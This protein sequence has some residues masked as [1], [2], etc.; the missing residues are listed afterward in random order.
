MNSNLKQVPEIN[1]VRLIIVR[2]KDTLDM[3]KGYEYLSPK[4]TWEPLVDGSN[5]PLTPDAIIDLARRTDRHIHWNPILRRKKDFSIFSRTPE[6][7]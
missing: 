4:K 1:P 2:L 6:A 5:K 7:A 3:S